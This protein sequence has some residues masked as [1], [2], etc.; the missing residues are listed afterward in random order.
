[1]NDKKKSSQRLSMQEKMTLMNDNAK[2]KEEEDKGSKENL[3]R[4]RDFIFNTDSQE[5]PDT[6]KQN[7]EV[8]SERKNVDE[9]EGIADFINEITAPSRSKKQGRCKTTIE[10]QPEDYEKL[11]KACNK[12]NL[13]M[14]EFIRKCVQ[15]I[16]EKM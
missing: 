10:W 1:M 7:I 5:N 11:I 3:D 9:N 13:S 14:S 8:K 12:T 16:L 2:R 15:R 4:G 6:K